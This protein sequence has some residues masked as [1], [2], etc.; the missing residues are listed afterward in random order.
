ME[1]LESIVAISG[2][3]TFAVLFVALLYYVMKTNE[4]RE[5]QYR[6]TITSLSVALSGYEGLKENLE[7]I[8]EEI[9]KINRNKQ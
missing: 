8:R 7:K 5:E 1:I 3:L 2:E 4:R 6:N 9:D